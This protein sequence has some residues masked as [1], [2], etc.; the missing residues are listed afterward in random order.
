MVAFVVASVLGTA[1]LAAGDKALSTHTA[2]PE[3]EWMELPFGAKATLV[4]G[5]SSQGWHVTYVKFDA[6]MKSM[7]HTHTHAYV[8]VVVTGT[9]GNEEGPATGIALVHSRGSGACQRMSARRGV[10]D[11]RLSRGGV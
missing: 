2:T 6:G 3:L 8:G 10:P 4:A 7:L 9:T 5:D 11:G 1:S